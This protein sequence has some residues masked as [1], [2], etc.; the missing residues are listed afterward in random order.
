MEYVLASASP[1]R[2]ELFGLI[3]KNFRCEVSNEEETVPKTVPLLERPEYL[4]CVKAQSV[5]KSNGTAVVI[6][7]DTA[8]F[9]NGEMLGKPKDASD[10]EK[11]LKALSGSSH[12]V[13]TGCCI[14]AGGN[15]FSFS[16]RTDVLF[17]DLSDDE[18][19]A[20]I[21]TGEP[22]DKAGSYAIQGGGALFVKEIRGDYLNVVGLPAARPARELK[23]LGLI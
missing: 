5:A 20:Y 12:A 6:G 15:K 4:A 3:T 16:E 9:I 19:A 2:R 23:R 22:F 17:Y 7:C 11:M 10:A 1:R 8:V 14:C 21:K 18:I 13:V